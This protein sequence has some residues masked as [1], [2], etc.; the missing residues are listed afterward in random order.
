[1]RT[2]MPWLRNRLPEFPPGRSA[3]LSAV[4]A[5]AAILCLLAKLAWAGLPAA[6]A[7]PAPVAA[8]GAE[9]VATSPVVVDGVTLFTV[10]GAASLPSRQRAAGIA[11]RIAQA[12]ADPRIDPLEV[13]VVEEGMSSAIIAGE[14]RLMNIVDADSRQEGVEREILS[15]LYL[16]RIRKAIQTYRQERSPDYLWSSGLWVLAASGLLLAG[17]LALR[18]LYRRGHAAIER[19]AKRRMETLEAKTFSLVRAQQLWRLLRAAMG[20]AWWVAFFLVVD[21]YLTYALGLFP[22]TRAF[23]EI[24]TNTVVPPLQSMLDGM[25]AALPGLVFIVLLVIVLRY[26]LGLVK[27]FFAGVADGSI[28]WQGVEPEW[29]FPTYR[30]IRL[31]VIAFGLVMAYPYIPGSSSEAFKGLSLMLGLLVSLGASSI[32]GNIMAG[33]SLIYR[34]AFKVGDR[35]RVGEHVGDVTEM[36]ALVTHLRTPKNEVVVVPNSEILTS[37]I[38]NYSALKKQEGIILHT[39]V[40][41]GYETPWRQVE[42]ML[43]MAAERTP[44]LLKAPPPFVLQKSLGD[45]CVVYEINAHSDAPEIMGRLYTALHQNILDVF[46]EYGVQIMTPAYEGDPDAPKVVPKAAWHAAP[47]KPPAAD[48]E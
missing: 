11:D 44:G 47:A 15:R 31:L 16:E 41:I 12:A 7:S 26:V 39:T 36:G 8:E 17:I 43:L 33:Y 10:R 46:N 18:W 6:A 21:A 2:I 32:I 42:A 13:K 19:I 28:H 4:R 9:K 25:T 1:M 20:L 5:L 30:L 48:Q 34:R 45:F 38:V 27:L 3:G 37:S 35:V 24:L 40:G 22:W 29:A 14:L 23:A